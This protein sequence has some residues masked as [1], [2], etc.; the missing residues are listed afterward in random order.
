MPSG[1]HSHE[2]GKDKAGK[3]SK[4]R[5]SVGDK[6]SKGTGPK[7]KR[8]PSKESLAATGSQKV[9]EAQNPNTPTGKALNKTNADT[10]TRYGV[11]ALGSAGS[12]AQKDAIRDQ[13]NDINEGDG[14]GGLLDAVFGLRERY[15][16]SNP[17]GTQAPA[18]RA[19]WGLDPA[20]TI[21]SLLGGAMAPGL[22][23]VTGPIAGAIS[24]EFGRPLEINL[25][26]DV[27][28]ANPSTGDDGFGGSGFGWGGGGGWGGGFG[29]GG[30]G[31]PPGGMDGAGHGGSD[32][33]D[34][35]TPLTPTQAALAG[36]PAP[37]AQAAQPA[38]LAAAAPAYGPQGS[39]W[40]PAMQGNGPWYTH[41]G[42]QPA[43]AVNGVPRAGLFPGAQIG[44]SPAQARMLGIT[45]PA[46]V[47]GI[48]GY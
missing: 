40:S 45:L 13:T 44:L 47:K 42:A 38:P 12:P 36:L 6:N 34:T 33:R 46:G 23:F 37:A 10:S 27:F 7:D 2:I 20:S 19:S 8:A 30:A 41:A 31:N 32:N 35:N 22:G 25:G 39:P 18:N 48:G 29:G 5:S 1:N 16:L 43:Q 9:S 15:D 11:G 21:G 26:P 3:P 28:G 4:D 24:D 17:V 14:V